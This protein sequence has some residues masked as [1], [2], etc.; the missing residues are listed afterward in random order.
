MSKETFALTSTRS[1][2][3]ATRPTKVTNPITSLP[4]RHHA[5]GTSHTSANQG[6]GE[7]SPLVAYAAT[8]S[9]EAT[10]IQLGSSP[11]GLASDLVQAS[12]EL[13]GPNVIVKDLSAIHNLGAMDVLC[14]D[15]TGTLTEDRVILEHHMDVMGREDAR[16][17]RHAY[18][19]SR[20]QTGLRNLIDQAIT[21]RMGEVAGGAVRPLTDGLRGRILAKVRELGDTGMRVVAV[22]QKTNP[23][24]IGAFSA[25]DER[26]M[27]LIGYLAFLDPP[28][29]SAR[30]AAEQL[31]ARGVDVKVLTGDNERVTVAVCAK[32]GIDAAGALTDPDVDALDDAELARRAEGTHL[33]AHLSPLQKARVV[34][35]LHEQGNH[36]V[37]FMGDGINDAAAMRASGCGISVDTAVDV[38]KESAGIILLRKDLLVLGRGILEGRRTYAN[39]IKYIKVAALSNFGNV[40]SVL[41]ASAF[42]PFLPMMAPQL[43][44]PGLAYTVSCAA[45]PW[46]NVDEALL[47]RPRRWDAGSIVSFMLW[48]GPMSSVFDIL[49]FAAMYFVVCPAR[50]RR[51][52]SWRCPPA[53]LGCSHCSWPATSRSRPRPRPS[54]CGATAACSS[55]RWPGPAIGS[56]PSRHRQR[57]AFARAPAT[58]NAC[59]APLLARRARADVDE[60]ALPALRILRA[61][62]LAA[63]L[64]PLVVDVAPV[65]V[66]QDLEQVLL[67]LERLR[68]MG[69]GREPHAVREAVHVRVDRDALHDAEAHVE[70]DVGG[71]A[72]HAWQARELGHR[73]RHLAAKVAHDH[74]R[75][76][77]GVAGL[78]LVEAETVDDLAHLLGRGLRERGWRGPAAEELRCH[79]VHL[80]VRSLGA[81]Q[82]RYDE[83]VGAL[84][85]EEALDRAIAPVEPLADLYRAGTLRGVRLTWH[86]ASP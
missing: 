21:D 10:L 45:L 68:G 4:L 44:L 6:T 7:L 54:T 64:D 32:V 77:D 27:V 20:F 15:K 23:R 71:L 58:P 9:V 67:G 14:C 81:E 17:L 72:P 39:T 69:L 82:H 47:E 12:R 11:R 16:V 34:R 8:H 24:G 85:V 78:G 63:E 31:Q 59:P 80:R 61:A 43:L 50:R 37:G 26:D 1:T 66:R 35:I 53:S 48:L 3:R 33:F 73:V 70:H 5:P 57:P 42:L 36:T 60:R 55:A 65:L 19:N 74:L 51:L 13:H 41:V 52:A 29:A 28:K 62:D 76:L 56:R 79:A 18:L 83:A 84:V 22:A 38:A 40:L 2:L 30:A 86:G 49:T 46:D 75:R 25:A